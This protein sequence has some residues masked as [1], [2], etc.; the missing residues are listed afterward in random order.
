[1][2]HTLIK[3]V[4][5]FILIASFIFTTPKNTA[6]AEG[7]CYVKNYTE[8]G[9][10]A[11]GTTWFDAYTNLD[12]AIADACTE[13][14]VAT[15]TYTPQGPTRLYSFALETGT[16]IYGGFAGTETDLNQR[17]TLANPTILSGDRFG[18]DDDAYNETNNATRS[19]NSIHVVVSKGA[20]HTAILDGFTITGGNANGSECFTNLISNCGGGIYIENSNP[21]L[22]NLIIEKNSANKGGGI[23]STSFPILSNITI[24]NN[25]ATNGGGIY[26]YNSTATLTDVVFNHNHAWD[27]GGMYNYNSAPILTNITFNG[28]SATLYGGGVYGGGSKITNATFSENYAR[29]GGG[30][31][32]LWGSKLTNVT[33]YAN[34]ASEKGGG[35]YNER[36]SSELINVTFS[37]NQALE[38][39]GIYNSSTLIFV[40]VLIANSIS[41][42]DCVNSPYSSNIDPVFVN[43][44]NSFIEDYINTCKL[45]NA[46]F[47]NMIGLDPNLGELSNHGG[48]TNSFELLEG[49]PA[50]DAGTNTKCPLTDQR[51][52]I[53]PQNSI[54]DIGSFEVAASPKI[55]SVIRAS[56]SPTAAT[57]VDYTVTFSEPVTD[58]DVDGSDFELNMSGIT[59]ASIIGVTG[60]GSSYTVSVNTGIGNG[61][62]RL[63]IPDTATINDLSGNALANLPYTVGEEYTTRKPPPKPLNAPKPSLPK[64]NSITS[65]PTPTFVWND[66]PNAVA[67]EIVIASDATFSQIVM[68]ETV[69]SSSFIPSNPLGDSKYFWRVRNFNLATQASKFSTTQI[70][71]IDTTPPAT[72]VLTSPMDNATLK[73]SPVFRWARMSDAVLY[74]FQYDN[75]PDLSTP[76]Y[77]IMTRNTYS[78]PPAMPNGTFFW[79]VRAQDAA[80]NWSSWSSICSVTISR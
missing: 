2:K 9:S 12:S 45:I 39:G 61:T 79:Q 16:A 35:L 24:I 31:Y 72:P 55:L 68:S 56:A 7:R 21:T 29:S 57:S 10:A 65:N 51:G 67:Y 48:S 28:N 43:S 49:S 64:W 52:M 44:K 5:A 26:N 13:I 50:I 38:G 60:S 46:N 15:G 74:E 3:L 76:T 70:F 40:N 62:L 14:W 6:Y 73:S 1:M 32:M 66:V 78:K 4:L 30:L 47:G 59:S 80:G 37:A 17:D 19:E 58:V 71:T 54:C 63:D 11:N 69:S 22:R 8:P 41:G 75:D 33:I 20:I 18:N 53:R 25:I 27:G 42:G 36:G 77:S 34:Q 23:F